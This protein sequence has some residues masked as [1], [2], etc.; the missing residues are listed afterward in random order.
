MIN[1]INSRIRGGNIISQSSVEIVLSKCGS[2]GKRYYT[3]V[4][5]DNKYVGIFHITT[6]RL[7]ELEIVD[8]IEGEK[9][10][11]EF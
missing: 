9:I 2:N 1:F 10:V 5:I 8:I 7:N 11:Y 4:S 3:I 6:S